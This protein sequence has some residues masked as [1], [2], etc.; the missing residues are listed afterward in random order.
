MNMQEAPRPASA[1]AGSVEAAPPAAM[2]LRTVS[3]SFGPVEALRDV[4]VAIRGGEVHAI[5]GENG[6]GKSTLIAIATGVLSADAGEVIYQGERI[7]RPAPWLMQE[8]GV[9]AV[10]QHPALAQDLTVLE[11]LQLA[12][13]N[14]GAAEAAAIF[15]RIATEQLRPSLQVRVDELSLAQRHVVEIARAWAMRP[16]IMIFDEPTE[17]FQ[18][19]DTRRL[20]AAIEELRAKGVG[21]VYVSH[22]LHE[23]MEI[24]DRVSVMR[25]GRIIDSRPVSRISTGEIIDLI[26]G[27]PLGQ[28]FPGKA[29]QVGEIL[30]NINGLSGRGFSNVDLAARGGE[31]VGLAGVEGEGQREFLRAIAGVG[32][33][34][35]G[36]IKIMETPVRPNRPGA[37]RRAGIGFVSDDRHSEGLFLALS[38]RENLGIGMLAN[39]ER[40]GI[41]DRGEEV[42]AGNAIVERLR[43]RTAS[44]ETAVS[45]LSGG[46][47]QKVLIGREMGAG[48]KVLL[49]DEPTK[50]V[51]VGARSEI[52]QRLRALASN[53]L[54][55]VVSS[56]DGIELEGLCD[57]VLIFARGHVVREL[58][59]AAVTDT[60][61]TAANLTATVSRTEHSRAQGGGGWHRLL[62]SD[63]F[64]ALVLSVLTAAVLAGMQIKSPYFL[65][66]FNLATIM[67][68]L[69]LLTFISIGQLSTILIGGIDLSVGAL[70]GTC[71]VLASFLTPA[72]V[73]QWAALGGA[74]VVILCA[75]L[76]GL[77]QGLLITQIGIPA[78]IVTLASFIGL[79]GLSL[80]L[81]PNPDGTISDSIS[82]ALGYPILGI[83][84]GM[85]LAIIAVVGLE[86]AL[87][88]TALGRRMRAVG[89][90]PLAAVR[91]G[92]D[93]RRHMLLAFVLAGVLTGIGG[94]MLAGQIGIGSADT[95]VDYT[96]MSITAVVLGGVSITGGRGSV[97]STLMGGALVQ[98][99][100]TASS[101]INADSSIH[102]TALG[103]ITM[104]AAVFFSIARRHHAAAH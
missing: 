15:A 62:S 79:Q 78:I 9:A 43:I 71:V 5:V 82:D 104:L 37:A 19:A 69:A 42:R 98:T 25:D 12:V 46:N 50:G 70:A 73:G 23:V 58:S 6:A 54:A 83:P 14:L 17:P 75:T 27:R 60:E 2:E 41:V 28:I 95:G 40:G 80:F 102:Y 29:V 85:I 7:A 68:F 87:H 77:F 44:L 8:L 63:H 103:V 56:S 74:L 26:A 93:V 1:A 97:L 30:L 47:Q 33:R 94:M 67:S 16:K 99:I 72:G 64:P 32:R 38:V 18:Q 88:W 61:I 86:Y 84:A 35:D 4:D 101:F 3:K 45:D 89:S 10:Y 90:N 20:F 31:I 55:V 66:S 57:R 92:I 59:D 52:Y 11:N 48:P 21:I 91:L 100:S 36:S 24:A 53:G 51:D 39:L 76:Y 22:R 96:I 49:V 81:R 13:P 34:S 65:T